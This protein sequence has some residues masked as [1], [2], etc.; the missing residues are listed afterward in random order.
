MEIVVV[1]FIVSWA[2]AVID[3][4][5]YLVNKERCLGNA[6]LRIVNFFTLS[7]GPLFFLFGLLLVLGQQS[8]SVLKAFTEAYDG[9]GLFQALLIPMWE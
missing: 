5:F 8:G 7:V 2:L 4:L 6:V 9:Y 1:I 3:F